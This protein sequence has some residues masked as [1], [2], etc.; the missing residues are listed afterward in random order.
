MTARNVSFL[1]CKKQNRIIIKLKKMSR[2]ISKGRRH[3]AVNSY[4]LLLVIFMSISGVF[5]GMHVKI[6][7][8]HPVPL[9]LDRVQLVGA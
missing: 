1:Q 2:Y 9:I 3:H 4:K 7:I 8:I 6:Y 5:K